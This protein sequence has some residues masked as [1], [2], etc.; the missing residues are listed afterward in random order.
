MLYT[1]V[2]MNNINS[3]SKI[4]VIQTTIKTYNLFVFNVLIFT[5]I[6][7]DMIYYTTS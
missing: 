5:F 6:I 7:Y 1:N 4:C 2:T 3:S